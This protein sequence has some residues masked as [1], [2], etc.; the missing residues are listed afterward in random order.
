[1][2]LEDAFQYIISRHLIYAGVIIQLFSMYQ[3]I[4]EPK[5]V[6]KLVGTWS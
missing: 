2:P 5:L 4:L 1:L 3:I 6:Q